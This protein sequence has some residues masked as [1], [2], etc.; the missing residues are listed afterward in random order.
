MKDKK[1][2]NIIISI[3]GCAMLILFDQYTKSLAVSKLMGKDPFV[4]IEGVFQLRY[5]ENRGAA[6]G[7]LQNQKVFFIIMGSIILAAIIYIFLKMPEGKKYFPLRLVCIFMSAG[8]IGN[9]I[10]RIIN[11]YVIDFFYF[12]LI[13]FPIFNVADCYVTLSAALLII[14]FLFYY[15]E[16]DLEFLSFKKNKK[17]ELS[18]IV[19]AHGEKEHE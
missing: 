15:S 11:N 1:I 18:N 5:L 10:D 16:K 12:E 6:F 8:A 2:I 7:I 14:L 17:E 19:D 3:V 4:M 13:D 9:M